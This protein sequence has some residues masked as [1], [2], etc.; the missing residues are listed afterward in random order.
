MTSAT[1]LICSLN[2]DFLVLRA[3]SSSFFLLLSCLSELLTSLIPL[4]SFFSAIYSLR[5][6]SLS[7]F[8]FTRPEDGT[9]SVLSDEGDLSSCVPGLTLPLRLDLRL[10]SGG[11]GRGVRSCGTVL[12]DGSLLLFA[13]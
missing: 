8:A 4:W 1:G 2:G 6:V 7:F 9:S 11:L 12:S 5:G 3:S 10:L 13:L